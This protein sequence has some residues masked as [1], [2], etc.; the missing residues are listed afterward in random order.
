MKA[1]YSGIFFPFKDIEQKTQ[2]LLQTA[3]YSRER[4]LKS[5][6]KSF[7]IHIQ[8]ANPAYFHEKQIGFRMV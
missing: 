6:G 2:C 1:V 4:E 8:H 3:K 7:R 5:T